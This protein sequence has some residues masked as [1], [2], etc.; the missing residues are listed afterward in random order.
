MTHDIRYAK[1]Q[2]ID[3]KPNAVVYIRQIKS[4]VAEATD[5][6]GLAEENSADVK[7]IRR[8]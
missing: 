4:E 2:P 8:G 6:E 7:F 1:P 3:V 5:F